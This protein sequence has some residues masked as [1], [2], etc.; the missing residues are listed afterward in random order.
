MHLLLS[1][2]ILIPVQC[3]IYALEGL[4]KL[5]DTIS[6][7][8][9]RLNPDLEIEGILLSM[10]DRRLRLANVVVNEVQEHSKDFVFETII[11]RNS[12]V[13]EAPSV[14]QPII[15]YDAG[16]RGASNFQVWHKSF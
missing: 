12:K 7:V 2:T 5:K 1:D 6:L 15:M 10:F 9:R 3:E 8:K 16:S 14:H 4:S 11:H 13:G